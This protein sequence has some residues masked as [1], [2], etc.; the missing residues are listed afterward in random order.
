MAG[1]ALGLPTTVS[2]TELSNLLG[3]N[4]RS[5]RDHAL[6]GNLVRAPQSGRFLLQE[7]VQKYTQ[8]L[9]D[10]AQGR[11]TATGTTLQ[12]E[13]AKTE[14]VNREIAEIKLAQLRA[15]TL[16]FAE[17]SES[18][19]NLAAMLKQKLLALPSKARSTIPHLT[20][21]DGQTL[22]TL[23]RDVLAELADEVGSGAVIGASPERLR[24][25]S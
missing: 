20:A 16:T 7:S 17:V 18:W 15:E 1:N 14:A 2:T 12:D 6:R 13:R 24:G 21:H 11:S 5:V 23:V 19:S 25:R 4:Q 10:Q 22:N 8:A 9:R 3:I